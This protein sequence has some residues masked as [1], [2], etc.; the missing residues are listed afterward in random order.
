MSA[1]FTKIGQLE[2]TRYFCPSV[3]YFMDMQFFKKIIDRFFVC[4]L[5]VFHIGSFGVLVFHRLNI[6]EFLSLNGEGLGLNS[7]NKH[8][9][10]LQG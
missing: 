8:Q 3:A 2:M 10:I 7:L 5:L 4:I 6:V 9:L 1:I